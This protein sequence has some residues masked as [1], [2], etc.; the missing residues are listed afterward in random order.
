M[1]LR[2]RLY[3]IQSCQACECNLNESAEPMHMNHPAQAFLSPR[4]LTFYVF[5]SSKHDSIFY[6]KLINFPVINK[7][8][9]Q[10]QNTTV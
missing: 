7:P 4:I 9:R 10:V 5:G 3:V 8:R 2:T 6:A 1:P